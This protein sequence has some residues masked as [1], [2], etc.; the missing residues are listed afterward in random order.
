L[1]VVDWL[2]LIEVDSLGLRRQQMEINEGG[3][4]SKKLSPPRIP[5][6]T[7]L[8]ISEGKR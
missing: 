5:P 3:E 7:S 6:L 8:R 2:Q 1:I 4:S